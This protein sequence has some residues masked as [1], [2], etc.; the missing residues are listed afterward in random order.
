[1]GADVLM[2]RMPPISASWRSGFWSKLL[3]WM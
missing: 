2:F 3:T 1:M